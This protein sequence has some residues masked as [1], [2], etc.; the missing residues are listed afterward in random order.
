MNMGLTASTIRYCRILAFILPII[1]FG[2]EDDLNYQIPDPISLSFSHIHVKGL[3][4]GKDSGNE[5]ET[6]NIFLRGHHETPCSYE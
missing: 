5:K 6:L 4:S 2:Y 1:T 3:L